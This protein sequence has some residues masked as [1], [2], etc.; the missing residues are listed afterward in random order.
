MLLLPDLIAYWLAGTTGAEVTNAS[1]TG[2]PDATTRTWSAEL[3]SRTGIPP[4]L[5]PGL[6]LPGSTIG[7]TGSGTAV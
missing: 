2:L 6:R 3:L 5:L 4:A 7:T 1:T